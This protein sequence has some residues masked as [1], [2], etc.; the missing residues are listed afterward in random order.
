MTAQ[1]VQRPWPPDVAGWYPGHRMHEEVA[2]PNPGA[3][4][5]AE[6]AK[7]QEEL[8]A[9]RERLANPPTGGEA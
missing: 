9:K 7:V 4:R 5:E 1:P 2:A 6:A 8:V 3:V